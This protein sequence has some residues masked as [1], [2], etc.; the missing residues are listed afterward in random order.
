MGRRMLHPDKPSVFPAGLPGEMA[1]VLQ[2]PV[3]EPDDGDIRLGSPGI[4]GKPR[5]IYAHVW[6]RLRGMGFSRPLRLHPWKGITLLLPFYREHVAVL[7]QSFSSRIPFEDRFHS[8]VGRSH[9]A[10]LEGYRLWV[11]VAAWDPGLISLFDKGGLNVCSLDRLED[12]F[13]KDPK[14]CGTEASFLGNK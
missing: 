14:V 11:V 1:G 10:G 7:P 2:F 9:A 8:L 5:H 13:G 6:Q 4:Q 12:L 3:P